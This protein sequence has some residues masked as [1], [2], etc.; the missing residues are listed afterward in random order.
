MEV[1]Y[2][3]KLSHTMPQ[4]QYKRPKKFGMIGVSLYGQYKVQKPIA[5]LI[6]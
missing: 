4:N 1:G 3:A 2:D 6:L 5:L